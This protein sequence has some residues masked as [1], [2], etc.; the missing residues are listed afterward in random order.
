MESFFK[1]AEYN[2]V[3]DSNKKSG[4]EW[5]NKV[6]I[7]P[8]S[9]PLLPAIIDDN[10]F[11]Q[12][13]TALYQNKYLNVQYCNP[14]GKTHEA[15]VMP[16]ALVQQ[17]ASS[18]LVVQYVDQKVRHL[19][20]HRLLKAEVSTLTFIRPKFDL[21]QYMA[22]QRFG[23]GQGKKIR[24]IFRIRKDVGFHLTETPLSTDQ[25][26]VELED[27]YQIEATVVES[28]MLDWW[29]AKFGD[30]IEEISRNYIE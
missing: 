19:A 5:L 1:Q 24:L 27:Q 13:S 4:S 14:S 16:L 15:Q 2:L 28:E 25:K 11:A 12:I 8:T 29:V 20:L 18:Y 17:G 6:A 26:I 9:Q 21:K 3:Y 7:A 10:I 22:E 23:F 30:D